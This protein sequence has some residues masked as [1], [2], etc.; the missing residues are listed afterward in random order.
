[1]KDVIKVVFKQVNKIH[2]VLRIIT[3]PFQ[4]Y[5]SLTDLHYVVGMHF[6]IKEC[7]QI[8]GYAVPTH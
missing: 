2:V 4:S 3:E 1:M 5:S 8:I 7:I 6:R